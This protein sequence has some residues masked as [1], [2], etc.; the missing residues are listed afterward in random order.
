MEYAKITVGKRERALLMGL[1][2]PEKPP[3]RILNIFP[4]IGLTKDSG[5]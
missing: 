1:N 2:R 3:H 5:D 4:T